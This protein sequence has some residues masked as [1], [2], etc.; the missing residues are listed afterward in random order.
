MTF[1]HNPETFTLFKNDKKGEKHPDYK[2]KG[3]TV[4]AHCGEE[5]DVDV[6]AWVRDFSGGKFLSGRVQKA[7]VKE[8]AEQK[9]AEQEPESTKDEFDDDL[10]F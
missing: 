8:D 2:G 10:P 4:C 3:K 5:T 9:E 6:A 7:W 1:E